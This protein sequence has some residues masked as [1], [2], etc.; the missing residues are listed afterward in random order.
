ML[1]EFTGT[2]SSASDQDSFNVSLSAGA[3]YVIRVE[4][5]SSGG[6]TLSDPVLTSVFDPSGVFVGSDDDSGP[7]F[8]SSFFYFG[9]SSGA[10]RFV[11]DG[12]GSSTGTYTLAVEELGTGDDSISG[13][14]SGDILGGARGND[15]VRGLGGDDLITGD[16]GNDL[17]DGGPGIDIAW[18]VAADRGVVANLL[19][20]I[21]ND[22][23]GSGGRDT[24]QSIE[25]LYGSDLSDQLTGNN[26]ANEL[27]G[28][29]GRDTLRGE[30]G[31]DTLSGG[32]DNDR[33]LGGSGNDFLDGMAG[34]DFLDG[35]SGSDTVFGDLGADTLRGGAGNDS[36]NG[37]NGRD[38]L[39]GGSGRDT[40]V[41]GSGTDTASYTDSFR[42]V[43]ASLESPGVNRGDARG[44]IYSQIEVLTGT[45]FNDSLGGDGNAQTLNGIGGSDGLY[46]FGA[47]DTLDGGSGNDT[48]DGGV[49]ADSLRGGSGFDYASYVSGT[50]V[51]AVLAWSPINTGD[52]VGDVYSSV[53]G[54][55]GSD[56]AD[57]LAG[58]F[59]TN[60]L[61]GAGGNDTIQGLSGS[62]TIDG[63][64]GR[65]YASY[66]NHGSSV[67]TIIEYTDLNTGPSANHTYVSIEGLIGT[68]F[69]D[70]LG[71]GL[72]D[73]H[74]LGGLGNDQLYGFD[75]D[76]TLEGGDDSDTLNGGEGADS[77]VGGSGTDYADYSI[78]PIGGTA[79]RA[80]LF[81]PASN[82]GDAAGDT[83]DSIEGLIGSNLNDTLQG[84]A[85]DN[86]IL[87][88]AGDDRIEGRGGADSLSGGAGND[89]FVY[90]ETGDGAD[91]ISGFQAGAGSDDIIE[92]IG[93]VYAVPGDVIALAVPSG[94]DTFIDFG[95]GNTLT[96][97]GVAPGDLHA[98]DFNIV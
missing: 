30:G 35:E 18:F 14:S 22:G 19:T 37:S 85:A 87:G 73:D 21:A 81:V 23:L 89:V 32:N 25:D 39:I 9:I 46:G 4:G 10:H 95:S 13:T 3:L 28:F 1:R 97:L 55:I 86:T 38:L 93:S 90:N 75:G 61:I 12:F 83:Y 69:D 98:D 40:L 80:S 57:W 77:L 96:L 6:G 50:A 58:S 76:D 59:G 26:Q 36:L 24:L 43:W 82:T 65:D 7:G 66:E 68:N 27:I 60:H 51:T 42:F 53:E 70:L 54:I 79:V 49:G 45:A 78:L 94:S 2:I 67:F 52:A 63:G 29:A 11:I 16:L 84:D 33:L 41:G 5:V 62:D 44:D 31:S 56:G 64:A 8:D 71:V 34:S 15:T 72:S 47:N 48:L 91:I 74:V 88:G 92:L 20:G 17:M